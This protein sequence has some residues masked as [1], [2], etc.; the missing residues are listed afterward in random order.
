[1]DFLQKSSDIAND[2]TRRPFLLV[3][4]V[5]S[6]PEVH[7]KEKTSAGS[8]KVSREHHLAFTFLK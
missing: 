7:F 3:F 2:L 1:M 6:L 4:L 8:V 5:T